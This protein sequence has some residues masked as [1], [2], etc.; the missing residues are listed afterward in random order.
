VGAAVIAESYSFI[1][2]RVPVLAI[3]IKLTVA[4]RG[5]TKAL[6]RSTSQRGRII[7]LTWS[8][9]RVANG[10]EWGVSAY[11]LANCFQIGL[12]L[13]IEPVGIQPVGGFDPAPASFADPR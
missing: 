11:R 8:Q 7:A 12:N 9:E 3:L 1:A 5:L 2:S 4:A 13:F 6:S 10:H